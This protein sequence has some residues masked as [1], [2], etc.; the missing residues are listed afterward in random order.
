[1][2]EI[3][4]QQKTKEILFRALESGRLTG[5]L[6]FVGPEGVGKGLMAKY[7]AQSVNCLNSDN[8]ACGKCSSC[9][10][11]EKMS[12][13]DVYC[14]EKDADGMVKVNGQEIHLSSDGQEGRKSSA[15]KIKHVRFLEERIQVRTYE[16]RKKVFII[17]EAQHLTPEAGNALLKT[18]EEP[19]GDSLIILTSGHAEQL[20]PTILSR[21]QKVRFNPLGP[22]ALE[23]ILRKDYKF[24]EKLSHFLAYFSQGRL[25]KAIEF[26]RSDILR[27][28]NDFLD[29]FTNGAITNEYFFNNLFISKR[30]PTLP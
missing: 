5:S 8:G 26:S 19:P 6:L 30:R 16:G 7:L 3:K 22:E 24:D 17:I 14:F 21:C 23:E 4:G 2:Q 27:E 29:N 25:G 12:H 11:I 18:L 28:K 9:L 10:K 20:L 13:L 15:I 1:M